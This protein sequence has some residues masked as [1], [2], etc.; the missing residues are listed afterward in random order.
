MGRRRQQ[1]KARRSPSEIAALRASRAA[2]HQEDVELGS[3]EYE[4]SRGLRVRVEEDWHGDGDGDGI[5]GLQWAGGV[6][7][8]RYFDEKFERG[9][10]VGK[11]CIE[12]G[13]GCGLTSCVLAGLGA[14]VDCTDAEP[15]HAA[16]AVAGNSA[17]MRARC[18]LEEGATFVAPR[19]AAFEWGPELPEGTGGPYDV[20]FAGD[21]LYAERHARAL[22]E[23]LE[24]CDA[25]VAFVCGAVGP[26]AHAAFQ[27]LA[28]DKFVVE[29]VERNH[30]RVFE[31][32]RRA[33]L[34][35]RRREVPPPLR[36]IAPATKSPLSAD[37]AA[38]RGFWLEISPSVETEGRASI[39][40]DG[41]LDLP[42]MV[43]DGVLGLDECA[44]LVDALRKSP[45][46]SFWAGERTE[47]TVAFRDADTLEFSSPLFAA[48]VWRRL[49]PHLSLRSEYVLED[50][51]LFDDPP[52]SWVPVGLNDDLLFASYSKT[53]AGFAPHTDGATRRGPNVRSFLSVIVYLNEPGDGETRFYDGAALRYLE[54]SG[55]RWTA[56]DDF[57]RGDVSPKP[58]RVLVFDQRLAHEGRPPRTAE[59]PKHIIRTDVMFERRPRVFD[60]PIDRE[61]YAAYDAAVDAAGANRHDDARRL[62]E[63]C[64]RLS[65][66]LAAACGIY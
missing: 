58:G 27:R 31:W 14:E 22:C 12:L 49:E 54:R 62:F 44:R 50:D 45:E 52:A 66:A 19:C 64:R 23:A 20:A 17:A 9:W 43:V 29:D 26:D 24:A 33:L 38:R 37:E 5:A 30:R 1:Q 10:W 28:T 61:A 63:H 56:P 57:A 46:A 65:P 8:A 59:T 39:S 55:N 48:E 51:A 53:T 4:F 47:D 11:R 25:T 3:L 6:R 13:A 7:L 36:A 15:R 16:A 34:R 18:E 60:A 32:D 21:C 2:K 40:I 41:G 35:L 42:T